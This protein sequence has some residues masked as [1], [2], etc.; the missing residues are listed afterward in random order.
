VTPDEAVEWLEQVDGRLYKSPGRG[1]TAGAWV[2]VVR[3]PRSGLESGRIIVALGATA[4]EATLAASAQWTD[5][6]R[7][8]GGLH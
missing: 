4:M 6:L 5:L 1:P 8:K 2:A 7:A 3:T